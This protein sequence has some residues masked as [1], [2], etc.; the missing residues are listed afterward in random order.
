[1]HRGTAVLTPA[2][3]SLPNLDA[4]ENAD[5][6]GPLV[7]NLGRFGTRHHHFAGAT[8]GAIALKQGSC[9]L[10]A[11]SLPCSVHTITPPRPAEDAY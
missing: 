7:N 11:S 6:P 8:Y 3:H 4:L 2:D 5:Y 10:L 1:M 9:P